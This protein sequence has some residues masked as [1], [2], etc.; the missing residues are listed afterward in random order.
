MPGVLS[1]RAR[2]HMPVIR[3]SQDKW[4]KRPSLGVTTVIYGRHTPWL[5]LE[6]TPRPSR[7]ACDFLPRPL[8]RLTLSS[9]SDIMVRGKRA[10]RLRDALPIAPEPDTNTAVNEAGT[11]AEHEQILDPSTSERR[12]WRDPLT[13]V[14]REIW[15]PGA[16]TSEAHYLSNC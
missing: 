14:Q 10:S 13:G 2:S 3:L 12:Y 8:T 1:A 9:A 6:H 11:P 7:E 15:R 4:L 5:H 16:F